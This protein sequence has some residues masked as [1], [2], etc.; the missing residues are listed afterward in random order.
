ME[1]KYS[2]ALEIDGTDAINTQVRTLEKGFSDLEKSAKSLDF[3]AADASAQK[4]AEDMHR[5][6]MTE[7]DSTE[8]ME[9]FDRAANRAYAE[10]EKSATKLNYS[11]TEQGREQR[12][13]IKELQEERACL[14]NTTAE[15]KRAKEI[16]KELK[17][18]RRDVV[19]AT[20][21]EIQAML[22][23]NKSARARLKIQQQE[24]RAFASSS[25]AQQLMAKLSAS[26]NKTLKDKLALVKSYASELLKSGKAWDAIKSKAGQAAKVAKGVAKGAAAVGGGLLAIGGAAIASA[27]SQVDR[28]K[29]ARR[30][31]GGG[32][33]DEKQNLLGEMYIST[34]ADYSTIVD[35]IN[36]VQ[37]VLGSGI[38][39]NELIEAATAEIQMPGA[40]AIFRQQNTEKATAKDFSAYVNR[41]KA[42]QGAT[43]ASVDQITNSASYVSNLRQSSFSNASE[44]DLQGLY[45]ALQG[46]GAYDSE[47]ELQRA[48]RAFVRVQ[49]T[50]GKDVFDLAQEWQKQGK[51]KNSE[52][53]A[54]NR[55]QID[56][57]MQN[58]DWAA[59]KTAANVTES[60]IKRTDA[61][62]VA[63]DV[64]RIEELKN[65][66]LIKVL[67]AIAPLLKELDM[68]ALQDIARGLIEFLST[69]VPLLVKAMKFVMDGLK[70]VIEGLG[71]L[72]KDALDDE[73]DK[74]Q[75][76][77]NG[78]AM[79]VK[80]AEDGRTVIQTTSNAVGGK[81][82][83]GKVLGDIKHD[84]FGYANGGVTSLPSL[85]GEAGPEAVIPLSPE[86]VGRANQIMQQVSQTFNMTGNETTAWSLSQMVRS[87]EFTIETGRTS[88]L[89]RRLGY[90]Y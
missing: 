83:A 15:K 31:K 14:G 81:V 60:G 71:A 4:L 89:N 88:Q 34:G 77:V 18:L 49:K 57:A 70:P 84:L 72:I 86:R 82:D 66:L 16:D 51:W 7:Q 32:S 8:Q 69:A 75:R 78:A 1:T 27:N 61:E 46:S 44:T 59:V 21:D 9:A 30:I 17:E 47:E 24:N 64:R 80:Q 33:M 87:R 23:S 39:K 76:A 85:I 13:R 54:T 53:G 3:S 11:L 26:E 42:L 29:E 2:I 28:E 90:G 37:T 50:S 25:K 65:E 38:S 48:F 56:N 40:A 35:A 12:E 6:L 73:V 41:M 67:Q 79:V 52:W 58:M 5:V 68:N 62:T 45:L 63:M 74:G 22:A 55:T 20:D 36:R 10:L 43:G 19:D